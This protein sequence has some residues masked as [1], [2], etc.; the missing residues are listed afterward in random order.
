MERVF[1]KLESIGLM[2]KATNKT[3]DIYRDELFHQKIDVVKFKTDADGK[4]TIEVDTNIA[5]VDENTKIETSQ[6]N[7]PF[8]RIKSLLEKNH[9]NIISDL[10]T[11]GKLL[12]ECSLIT[13]NDDYEIHS[14]K[15]NEKF[16]IPQSELN[17]WVESV[18]DGGLFDIYKVEYDDFKI[19]FKSHYDALNDIASA[20]Q[21]MI[22]NFHNAEQDADKI[23]FCKVGRASANLTKDHTMPVYTLETNDENF[24]IN[25]TGEYFENNR[26]FLNLHFLTNLENSDNYPVKNRVM[27][28]SNGFSA[29]LIKGINRG[30]TTYS[31][32]SINQIINIASP[33]INYHKF[34]SKGEDSEKSETT[35]SLKYLINTMNDT[36]EKDSSVLNSDD[37]KKLVNVSDTYFSNSLV[38]KDYKGIYQVL[39]KIG[40]ALEGNKELYKFLDT[41]KFVFVARQYKDGN[42]YNSVKDYLNKQ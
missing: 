2:T 35:N 19:K 28:D 29:D 27:I 15:V 18:F 39:E 13:L 41:K 31:D 21:F 30:E 8:T 12:I 5:D 32:F 20:V 33:I 17:E 42:L 34:V 1:S 9:E 25:E 37:Q 36:T 16:K 24:V 10:S 4:P 3:K 7:T 38:C 14:C 40:K 26:L 23:P 22:G 6:S 11:R